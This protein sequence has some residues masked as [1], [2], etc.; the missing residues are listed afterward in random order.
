M[1]KVYILNFSVAAVSDLEDELRYCYLNQEDTNLDCLLKDFRHGKTRWSM[2]KCTMPGDIVVFMCTLASVDNIGKV[3]SH[4][5]HDTRIGFRRYLDDLKN[6]YKMYSG[7]L[8]GYGVVTSKP[9]KDEGF[10]KWM[11]DVEDLQ[12]FETPVHISDFRSFISLWQG[13]VTRLTD[14]QWERLKWVICEKNPGFFND[15]TMPDKESLDREHAEAEKKAAEKTLEQLRRA[16]MKNVS[17]PVPSKVQTTYYQRN[18]EIS[19]FVK[20][21]ANG[22]CQLCGEH[23]PFMKDNGEPYLECHH[24]V[25][26]ADGGMDSPDNCVALCPNC[27]RK[28]HFV[29]DP[30]D[31]RKLQAVIE[32]C[33]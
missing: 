21:R 16:A 10:G 15:V 5:P 11:G 27:H 29:D 12:Q 26:L 32:A 9:E 23:A 33:R 22:Y 24:I 17:Q 3:I 19:V 20:R 31:R 1:G 28:M 6:H 25:R 18:A 2:F 7:C 13:S 30:E 14:E 4:L 8:L